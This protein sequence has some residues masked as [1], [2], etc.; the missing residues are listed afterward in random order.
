MHDLQNA[1][2]G[3]AND[4]RCDVPCYRTFH[5]KQNTDRS[6]Y[7]CMS[8]ASKGRGSSMTFGERNHVGLN[9]HYL[10]L[11]C[12]ITGQSYSAHEENAF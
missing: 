8:R 11:R 6:T 2:Q 10:A 5:R 7:C 1:E 12:C 9:L 3:A 4:L